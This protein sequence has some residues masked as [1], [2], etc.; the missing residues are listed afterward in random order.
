MTG[1][2]GSCRDQVLSTPHTPH[3]EGLPTASL[4]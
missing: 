1:M 4:R 3:K 2:G